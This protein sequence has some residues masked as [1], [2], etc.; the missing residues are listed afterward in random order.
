[1]TNTGPGECGNRGWTLVMKIDG[2]KVL[3]DCV[4]IS[5]YISSRTCT[6]ITVKK[7][8]AIK[9]QNLFLTRIDFFPFLIG[10]E[11]QFKNCS[12]DAAELAFVGTI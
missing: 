11:W 4:Y 3:P 8:T 5:P 7:K 2:S 10:F 9:A 6:K 12:R 1:M